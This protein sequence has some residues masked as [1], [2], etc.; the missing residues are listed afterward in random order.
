MDCCG[1]N[2]NCNCKGCRGLKLNQFAPIDTITAALQFVLAD[3]TLID[4]Q[5]LVNSILAMLPNIP[6]GPFLL[7]EDTDP[8]NVASDVTFAGSVTAKSFITNPA[9][10]T[11]GSN[12]VIQA[13]V[14]L[15]VNSEFDGSTRFILD[16]QYNE[17]GSFDITSEKLD[18]LEQIDLLPFTGT[19]FT[20]ISGL[21]LEG[22]SGP[23]VN[24]YQTALQLFVYD[25]VVDL[26]FEGRLDS[27]TGTL[28][29]TVSDFNSSAPPE[30]NITNITSANPA[31]VTAPGHSY[32][33]GDRVGVGGVSG[34][35]QVNDRVSFV[36]VSGN[37]IT[38]TEIDS[39]A[40]S[41]YG[42]GGT[43]RGH[44]VMI[45]LDNPSRIKPSN[46]FFTTITVGEPFDVDGTE[47]SPNF[48]LPYNPVFGHTIL[49]VQQIA[50]ISD[51]D[52]IIKPLSTTRYVDPGT[53]SEPDV[54]DG[55]QAHP[56]ISILE[57]YADITDNTAFNPYQLF[58]TPATYDEGGVLTT[59][60]FISLTAIGNSTDTF[61]SNGIL[62]DTA[63]NHSVTGL[64]ITGNVDISVAGLAGTFIDLDGLDV[65]LNLLIEG[66][67]AGDTA[68]DVAASVFAGQIALHNAGCKLQ[69]TSFETQWFVLGDG[70]TLDANGN[71]AS[72]IAG[73]CLFTNP[74]ALIEGPLQTRAFFFSCVIDAA[75]VANDS[76]TTVTFDSV[77]FP[78][79]LTLLGGAQRVLSSLAEGTS[80]NPSSSPLSSDN[81]QDAIDELANAP[82]TP[83][84]RSNILM[85]SSTAASQQPVATDTPLQIEFGG[86]QATTEFDLDVNGGMTCNV[87]GQYDFQLVFHNGR[88]GSVDASEL[89]IRALVNGSQVGES[90]HT[91]IDDADT[92]VPL[93]FFAHFTLVSTDIVTFEI[94]RDS[95]GDDSGGLFQGDP[96]LA[97]WNNAETAMVLISQLR[98]EVIGADGDVTGPASSI[99]DELAT[100]S[101]A[102]GK[103]L[104]ANSGI[105]GVSGTLR[106]TTTDA[107]LILDTNGTGGIILGN[108]SINARFGLSQ[109][110]GPVEFAIASNLSFSAQV[111]FE[112][113]GG[114]A[115]RVG[116]SGLNNNIEIVD[117]TTTKGMHIQ[118]DGQISLGLNEVEPDFSVTIEGDARPFG[119][120]NLTTAEEASVTNRQ[121]ML[122]YNSILD[123]VRFNDGTGFRSLASTAATSHA[124]NRV[125]TFSGVGSRIQQSDLLFVS[126]TISVNS[127]PLTVEPAVGFTLNL[128][129]NNAVRIDSGGHTAIGGL[130]S[131]AELA[132]DLTETDKAMKLNILTQPTQVGLTPNPG[133]LV[134]VSSSGRLEWYNGTVWRQA[135]HLDDIPPAQFA[136]QMFFNSFVKGPNAPV[137]PA[138]SVQVAIEKHE[139]RLDDAAPQ[140]HNEDNQENFT[141]SFETFG[142]FTMDGTVQKIESYVHQ[143]GK[144]GI[145]S[146]TVDC[147][148]IYDTSLG[149][150]GGHSGEV[151]FSGSDTQSPSDDYII[152]ASE[153]MAVPNETEVPLLIQIRR[154][155]GLDITSSKS[156]RVRISAK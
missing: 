35:T 17:N 85:A 145:V 50:F 51:I 119:L 94:V 39:S 25:A 149:D 83:L 110:A 148:I 82:G 28:V 99:D 69:G 66:N 14:F 24:A 87:D 57:A 70:G 156:L 155:S 55:S 31:V 23:G 84:I 97:D 95:S 9:S 72:L 131:N 74:A 40:F 130:S 103:L 6:T 60:P 34:M 79:T 27:F 152:T 126:D 81:V 26:N 114:D 52:A 101:G 21:E 100:Y 29:T 42:G 20:F 36:E 30:F 88:L 132:L 144:S 137:V 7:T 58:L 128:G 75:L 141:G 16:R 78:Q 11:I 13:G 135:A 19:R 43:T 113:A 10:L 59:K 116:Y 33:T 115:G 3:N 138:D 37:D 143:Y 44:L 41:P 117:L 5:T 38:F 93:E 146:V 56:Y 64:E 111:V 47:I 133:W 104:K 123:A 49:E 8:Q 134:Y 118:P 71:S 15:Q 62:I 76:L 122:S 65:T 77:S 54:R 86:V 121:R 96:T 151:Y 140:Y 142:K 32:I 153:D 109:N 4:Y 53:D 106:R 22:G 124:V 150:P 92:I 102:T 98:G 139:Q 73:G 112:H 154:S 125:V 18:A 89:Y 2:N 45:P 107:D 12:D 61:L 46:I 108:G 67:G 91:V 1:I 129:F 105:T 80:F 120:P 48:F 68:V 127:G 136:N 147:Q 63:G 90:A